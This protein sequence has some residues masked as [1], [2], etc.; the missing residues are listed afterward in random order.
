MIELDNTYFDLINTQKHN[1]MIFFFSVPK[2]KH[3]NL[4]IKT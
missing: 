3:K 1:A 4:N 2:L